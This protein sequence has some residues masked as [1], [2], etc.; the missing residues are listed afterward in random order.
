MSLTVNQR[1]LLALWFTKEIAKEGSLEPSVYNED[2]KV[3]IGIYKN[4]RHTIE[5]LEINEEKES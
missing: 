3:C 4:I 2:M 5:E 1:D